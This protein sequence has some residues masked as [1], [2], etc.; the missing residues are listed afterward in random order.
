[1]RKKNRRKRALYVSGVCLVE[2]YPPYS[3]LSLSLSPPLN[4][5]PVLL[6][7]MRAVRLDLPGTRIVF[8][9]S[10]LSPPLKLKD[11]QGS[12]VPG[13]IITTRLPPAKK[14]RSGVRVRLSFDFYSLVYSAD[15][16]LCAVELSEDSC[17]IFFQTCL[18]PPLDAAASTA[19][20]DAASASA[21]AVAA[22]S[23]E[24]PYKVGKY[25]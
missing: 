2:V 6:A 20:A 3:H 1:V 9:S 7:H 11:A 25:K 16:A 24:T 10:P 12:H 14:A 18:P 4:F 5:S 23:R 17:A 15:E 8:S 13:N 21:A 19:A 22:F